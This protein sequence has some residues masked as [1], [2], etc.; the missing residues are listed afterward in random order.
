MEG[1]RRKQRGVSDEGRREDEKEMKK[2]LYIYN[3]YILYALLKG[4]FMVL[5]R[6]DG[7]P[8][9]TPLRLRQTLRRSLTCT[10]RKM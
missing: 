2:G 4:R 6:I 8:P 9:Q 1:G 3:P 10:S 5:R 7:V